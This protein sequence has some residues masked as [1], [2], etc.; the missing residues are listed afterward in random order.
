MALNPYS[1]PCLPAVLAFSLCSF[2]LSCLAKFGLSQGCDGNTA[3]L[4][5]PAHADSEPKGQIS[6]EPRTEGNKGAKPLAQTH[7]LEHRCMMGEGNQRILDRSDSTWVCE[8]SELHVFTWFIHPSVHLCNKAPSMPK[9]HSRSTPS[10]QAQC[11]LLTLQ[12]PCNS[13][14][15]R[16]CLLDWI[17]CSA[18]IFSFFP[19]FCFLNPPWGSSHHCLQIGVVYSSYPL[20][21]SKISHP[22]LALTPQALNDLKKGL[23]LRNNSQT[24]RTEQ[25]SPA[26][27]EDVDG[28]RVE[29]R[30][31]E[32]RKSAGL[33]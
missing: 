2:L 6:T 32:A 18:L 8:S 19:R 20:S 15:F 33:S 11:S 1:Q 29:Q 5:E 24:K 27:R 10:T 7:L 21:S 23:G 25:L 9:A 14:G 28:G 30:N 22:G 17:P 12:S 31:S 4:K 16:N 3:A 13:F 26:L